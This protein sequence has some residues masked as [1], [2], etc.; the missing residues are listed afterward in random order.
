VLHATYREPIRAV[1]DFNIRMNRSDDLFVDQLRTLNGRQLLAPASSRQLVGTLHGRCHHLYNVAGRLRCVSV[2]DVGPTKAI[3]SSCAAWET[4]Q[5]TRSVRSRPFSS[6]ACC[7]KNAGQVIGRQSDTDVCS[8]TLVYL[9]TV[10]INQCL[11]CPTPTGWARVRGAD[12]DLQMGDNY[13][14]RSEPKKVFARG[15]GIIHPETAKLTMLE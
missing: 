14:E 11:N 8:E 6:V 13:G 9:N 12:S 4:M 5:Y 15:G 1:G 3:I 7:S 10:Q 2:E